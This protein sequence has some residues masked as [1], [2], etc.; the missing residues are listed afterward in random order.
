M[1]ELLRFQVRRSCLLVDQCKS[2]TAVFLAVLLMAPFAGVARAQD[3]Y[4]EDRF[5]YEEFGTTAIGSGRYEADLQSVD[6]KRAVV[7]GQFSGSATVPGESAI[8]TVD[9]AAGRLARYDIRSNEVTL[10]GVVDQLLGVRQ[11]V[12]SPGKRWVYLV[13]P[14]KNRILRYSFETLDLDRTID[15]SALN[16]DAEVRDTLFLE[17]VTGDEGRIVIAYKRRIAVFDEGNLVSSMVA[18]TN[19]IYDVIVL[20][21]RYGYFEDVAGQWAFELGPAGASKPVP[22]DLGESLPSGG[23][24]PPFRAVGDELLRDGK[25]VKVPELSARDPAPWELFEQDPVL[26]IR[27]DI[28]TPD[29]T[30]IVNDT[31]EPLTQGRSCFPERGTVVGEGFVLEPMFLWGPLNFSNVIDRCGA[32]GEFQP[33]EPARLVDTRDGSGGNGLMGRLQGGSTTR[34][35]VHGLEG[36]PETGVESVL[37]N[38]TAVNQQNDPDGWNFVTVWP[39]GYPQPTVSNLNVPNGRTVGNQV[40]VATGD[41]GSVDVYTDG[42]DV[43]LTVDVVGYFSSALAE[44]GHRFE[45][46]R[47]KR[48]VDTRQ[49]GQGLGPSGEVAVD[50]SATLA[51]EN[52]RPTDVVAAIVNVTAIQ[53]TMSSF[54][55]AYAQGESLPETSA[56]NFDTGAN[57]ARLITVRTGPGGNFVLRNEVGTVDVAVD[58]VGVYV[59]QGSLRTETY[60]PTQA[61]R[62]IGIVPEREVD[63]RESTPFDGDGRLAPDSYIYLTGY[64]VGIHLLTN[65]TAVRTDRVGFLSSG[66][67]F[68]RLDDLGKTSSLNYWAGSRVA[69]QAIIETGYA[70][71]S[72]GAIGIYSD[73][74]AHVLMDVFGF[75]TAA[76]IS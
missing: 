14:D 3:A 65:L 36:I 15:L 69:N 43:H 74:N 41:D 70:G 76:R 9:E 75:Y 33:V 71:P 63:T 54:I 32:Y 66:P 49:T 39:A 37:L 40:T 6:F 29:V 13:E 73:S 11:I 34:I 28:S 18:A 38:V 16:A 22:V 31:G 51:A 61:G 67:L 24:F 27:Y 1:R 4:N 44:R 8:I 50:L 17:T 55:R 19:L 10:G 60:G 35:K 57:L 21:G 48:V 42:G 64:R 72:G 23:S 53:P 59:R 47:T 46:V 58:L 30:T 52:I 5:E 12:L 2:M 45:S 20:K 56:A 25:L 26:P 7:N 68:E 62:F